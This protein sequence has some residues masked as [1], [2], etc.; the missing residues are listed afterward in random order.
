[1]QQNQLALADSTSAVSIDLVRVYRA[2]GGGWQQS[3]PAA[4]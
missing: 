1:L 4:M 3:P 2:L